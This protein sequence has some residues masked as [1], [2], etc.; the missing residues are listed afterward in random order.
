V[1]KPSAALN[2]LAPDVQGRIL[3]RP[4]LG[5]DGNRQARVVPRLAGVENC[6]L[7]PYL[8]IRAASG[9]LGAPGD[10]QDGGPAAILGVR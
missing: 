8:E 7:T 6:Y 10:R 5:R 3:G 4:I 2:A 9:G 1:R